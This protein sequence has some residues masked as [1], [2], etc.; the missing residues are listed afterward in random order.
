MLAEWVDAGQSPETF[1]DQTPRTYAAILEGCKRR[2]MRAVKRD[3][4]LAWRVENFSRAGKKFKN[5]DHYLD[6]LDASSITDAADRAA[7]IFKGFEKRGLATIKERKR[8]GG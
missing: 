8:D 6:Q 7:A 1:D 4:S 2:E 5:L 3:L